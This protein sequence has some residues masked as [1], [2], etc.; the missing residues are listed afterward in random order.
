MERVFRLHVLASGSSGNASIVEDTNTGKGVLI[1]CGIS[2]RA[3]LE[4]CAA[5]GFDPSGLEAVVVTH[6]HADH[7][8]G[9]GVVMRGLSKLGHRPPLYAPAACVSA[10]K[11]LSDLGSDFEMRSFSD[12]DQISAAGMSIHP[13]RTAHDA[14]ASFGFRFECG[15]DA[16]G[17][18]TDTGMVS[19]QVR[20]ALGD[21]R[22]LGLEANHGLKMLDAADYPA[23]VKSRIA[24]DRGH[25]NN[26]QSASALRTL[27]CP[28]L[29]A[30]AA[31]HVSENANTYRAAREALSGVVQQEG[32]HASVQVGYQRRPI[33]VG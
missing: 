33:L 7:V 2:K 16:L 1:D 24:S 8:K 28:R 11:A 29:E 9:L 27:L 5:T 20:E 12:A 14:A 6:E 3:F 25:L 23:Y 10:S 32:H 19:P 30:V 21:V 26:D 13:F 22:I 31:L 17:F 15:G 4:G 18:A